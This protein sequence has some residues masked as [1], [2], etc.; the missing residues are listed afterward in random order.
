MNQPERYEIPESD[1]TKTLWRK[2]RR[3]PEYRSGRRYS[4]SSIHPLIRAGEEQGLN[5]VILKFARQLETSVDIRSDL[6]HRRETDWLN[7]W[8]SMHQTLFGAIYRKCGQIRP[9]GYDVR[10]GAPGDEELHHIPHGGAET[11]NELF[12]LART[13]CDRLEYIEVINID[14]VC[15]FLA[16]FHYSFIRIHPFFDGNG[17]IAR[18]VTDQ[19]AVA[20]GFIPII[21]GFPRNN[22][23]K[24][25][26][27]HA[28]IHASATDSSCKEL[29]A[30][31]KT[32]LTEKLAEIA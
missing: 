23:D 21:A 26:I 10:F 28:A 19:L 2:Y 3:T 11:Y 12:G 9:R 14:E 13:L 7:D 17:R 20:L 16:S 18:V 15:R 24:K 27:Y 29:T 5:N 32:Q 22:T 25:R 1:V 4:I 6:S 30:W 31:I 8:Q